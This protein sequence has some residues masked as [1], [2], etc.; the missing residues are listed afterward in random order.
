MPRK[1]PDKGTEPPKV[2]FFELIVRC[3][4]CG[5]QVDEWD[6]GEPGEDLPTIACEV[7]GDLRFNHQCQEAK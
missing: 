4:T 2:P 3:K 5:A 7:A 6:L 1:T